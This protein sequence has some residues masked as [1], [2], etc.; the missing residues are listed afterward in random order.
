MA[1]RL[2][3][4][5]LLGTERKALNLNQLPEPIQT[6]LQ[7][8]PSASAEQQA[9]LALALQVPYER[10]GRQPQRLA[11]QPALPTL[12]ETL[13]EAP[14]RW[15]ALL[16]Q[17]ETLE[18]KLRDTLVRQ[19]ARE[20]A[21]QQLRLPHTA[22]MRTVRLGRK[23]NKDTKLA[24]LA[25]LG[26]RG[27]WVVQQLPEYGYPVS[28]ELSLGDLWQEGTT[29]QRK[30][31]LTSYREENT[32]QARELL[33]STWD[34]ESIS[35]KRA[36]LE[37]LTAQAIPTDQ[38]WLEA[39]L[40]GEFAFQPREKK[41]ER[42]CRALVAGALLSLPES[43]LHQMVKK[44]LLGWQGQQKKGGLLGL[45]A[46]T[47]VTWTLP[48]GEDAFWNE[49]N[50]RA[51]LGWDTQNYDT[52]VF[53]EARLAWLHELL[54]HWPFAH[55]KD[56]VGHSGRELVNY[57]LRQPEYLHQGNPI[58]WETL[59]NVAIHQY[60][61]QLAELLYPLV[62]AN[63][64][65]QYV[66][67]LTPTAFEKEVESLG[68]WLDAYLLQQS[69]HLITNEH[70]SFRFS[71]KWLNRVV[72]SYSQSTYSVP[73]SLG[74]AAA[75]LFPLAAR[76]KLMKYHQES[77]GR[78]WQQTWEQHVYLPIRAALDIRETLEAL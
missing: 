1:D 61:P 34:T 63:D 55:W 19:W 46:K 77:Q 47:Q 42:E 76:S 37:I 25:I 22:L 56:I 40:A 66:R 38:A 10:A 68:A 18:G 20:I 36:F 44:A 17:L 5:L 69:P 29:A 13:P 53:P 12:E 75:P 67:F 39:L 41:T 23:L 74:E 3:E 64:R 8:Q 2:M 62:A 78:V 50:L 24:L 57:W 52:T 65:R 32:D 70:W 71:E 14:E 49:L 7:N 11:E 51:L 4:T 73:H 15:I 33:R 26:E 30:N 9:L 35:Q 28:A 45:G 59:W 72:Q 54:V 21:K 58:F 6:A 31:Y 27:R 48:R 60:I 43:T 16:P